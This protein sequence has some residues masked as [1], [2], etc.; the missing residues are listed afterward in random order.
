MRVRV[1]LFVA[2]CAVIFRS[3]EEAQLR[4]LLFSEGRNLLPPF[5]HICPE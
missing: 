4:P 5:L 3:W 2:L 1:S